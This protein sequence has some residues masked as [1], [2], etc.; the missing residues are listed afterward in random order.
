[1]INYI[2]YDD[3]LKCIEHRKEFEKFLKKCALN[4]RR[5]KIC[6]G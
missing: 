6:R 4:R 1:M 5:K 2:G 3:L